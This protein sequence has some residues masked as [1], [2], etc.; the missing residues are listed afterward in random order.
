MT[1]YLTLVGMLIVA[2]FSVGWTAKTIV[3]FRQ[4][5]REEQDDLNARDEWAKA[6]EQRQRRNGVR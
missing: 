4:A 3:A 1:E 6:Y 5:E 2:A